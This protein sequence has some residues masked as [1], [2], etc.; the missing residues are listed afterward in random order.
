MGAR[1]ILHDAGFCSADKGRFGR[2]AVG[3]CRATKKG[4]ACVSP[5][6][7]MDRYSIIFYRNGASAHDRPV[8]HRRRGD[9]VLA[10][11]V[12]VEQVVIVGVAGHIVGQPSP[13]GSL[14]CRRRGFGP[15]HVSTVQ[16]FLTHCL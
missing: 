15:G 14:R 8:R 1:I 5:S 3:L 12:R 13:A 11:P 7:F 16:G 4:E 9:Q 10:R 6:K 2:E